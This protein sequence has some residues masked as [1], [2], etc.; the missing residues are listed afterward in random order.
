MTDQSGKMLDV[1]VDIELKEAQKMLDT[2]AGALLSLAPVFAGPI[3]KSVSQMFLRRFTSEGAW[4]G[5]RW[6]PLR[7]LTL[8]LRQR[9][10]HGRGGVLRD[11]NR[12]FGSLVKVGPES[13]RIISPHAYQRGTIVP[14]AR[15]QQTGWIS[16]LVFG[17]SKR[18]V[19]V[20]ARPPVPSQIPPEMTNAWEKVIARFI[21][22]GKTSAS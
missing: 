19:R 20:P 6:A 4:G 10:G 13:I 8:R 21:E 9:A 14:Y 18:A 1:S 2:T 12:L 22:T 16:Q 17:R 5:S 15:F 11:T 7:P 3:D